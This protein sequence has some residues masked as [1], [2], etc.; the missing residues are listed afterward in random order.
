MLIKN[1]KVM[2]AGRPVHWMIF[3]RNIENIESDNPN[4]IMINP[5]FSILI[6]HVTNAWKTKHIFLVQ[7]FF[8]FV[9]FV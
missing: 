1:P 3:P 6:A 7:K 2:T 4:A 9:F 5:I 8:E